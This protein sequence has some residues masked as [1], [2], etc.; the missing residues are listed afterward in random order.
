[1]HVEETNPYLSPGV[2]LLIHGACGY[3]SHLAIMRGSAQQA[4]WQWQWGK[5]K[6]TW[7][8]IQSVNEPT[9]ASPPLGLLFMEDNERISLLFKLF[10]IKLSVTGGQEHPMADSYCPL[11]STLKLH[12]SSG[13]H[14]TS[15]VIL[16][17]HICLLWSGTCWGLFLAFPGPGM[18]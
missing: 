11:D 12:T 6:S 2:S 9:L 13:Y 1:M 15:R 4:E 7:V 10:V 16:W 17:V 5:V 14:C 18:E 3:C 8:C